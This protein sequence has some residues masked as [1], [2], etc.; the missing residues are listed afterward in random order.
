MTTVTA[1]T[2]TFTWDD[3]MATAAPAMT[4]SG[5]EFYRAIWRREIPMPPIARTLGIDDGEVIGA[6]HVAV[7]VEPAEYHYNPIGTVHGG[8]VTTLLDTATGIAVHTTLPV[9]VGFTTVELKVNFIRPITRDTGR[10]RCEGEVVH[11][12]RRVAVAEGRVVDA[13][14]KLYAYGTATCLVLRPDSAD[15]SAPPAAMPAIDLQLTEED[16]GA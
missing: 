10:I 13:A 9:G 16:V 15:S 14:G 3:P 11:A 7:S 1:R 6:G 5:L 12:G 4:M 8:L 2:R